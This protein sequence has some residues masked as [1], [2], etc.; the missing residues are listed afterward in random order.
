MEKNPSR[1]LIVAYTLASLRAHYDDVIANLVDAGVHVSIRYVNERGLSADD[2]A[3]S[4][5]RRGCTVEVNPLRRYKKRD[6]HD[7]L[8]L[9]LR[10]LVNLLRFSHPDY[11]GREWLRNVKLAR[12]TRSAPGPR[13]WARRL[14]RLGRRPG[15]A[16]MRLAS[17]IERLLPPS[18]GAR[19]LIAEERPDAVAVVGIVFSPGLV[20]Y[21]KA[22]AWEGIPTASWVQSWDNLTNKGL[23][24]FTPDRVFVWNDFQRDELAR[25]HGIPERHACVT[26]AQTF[27]HWFNGGTPSSRADFCAE[28]GL[29]PERPIVV[30][31]ASSLQI[32]PPLAS[33]FLRWLQAIRS[34]GDPVL[35]EATV[36]VRPHP[37]YLRPWLELTGRHPTLAVSPSV[38]AA[39]INS[40]EYRQRFR[41]ELHHASVAVGLN[42]S[43]MIDAA[44]L[45]KPVCT[46]ELPDV[47]NRQRGTI[48]FEY[49]VT[50]G[51]GFLHTAT[52]FGEHVAALGELVRKD[53]EEQDERSTRF[54]Q[55]FIRPHGL[56]PTPTKVFSEEMLRLLETPPD[57]PLP[58]PSGRAIGRLVYR[59]SP[60]LGVPL[61]DGLLLSRRRRRRLEKLERRLRKPVARMIGRLRKRARWPV[62]YWRGLLLKY[63]TP[64]RATR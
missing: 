32:E 2:Y 24:H 7:R 29:D 27:D 40:P 8:P 11:R 19:A 36:L 31:L 51:G 13:R 49:L 26:G 20:D 64:R 15:L 46:V 44:I 1:L 17:S 12:A 22:A 23:L 59:A 9:R 25:Y 14:A 38:A 6:R 21:L 28:N 33:F 57:V 47:P 35:E 62:K 16:A 10:E 60:V 56:D 53:F 54:L 52:S 4:L 34:S 30:Y 41:D 42:T 5:A 55:E 43:A 45:G 18:E 48:H 37:T 50:V 58:S 39:P 63:W 3:T 61:E